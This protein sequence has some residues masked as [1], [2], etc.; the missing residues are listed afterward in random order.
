MLIVVGIGELSPYILPVFQEEEEWT[1]KKDKGSEG[2]VGEVS[3]WE[4]KYTGKAK[5][6]DP[7]QYNILKREFPKAAVEGVFWGN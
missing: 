3:G 5:A 4:G 7:T 1:K 6:E 2:A